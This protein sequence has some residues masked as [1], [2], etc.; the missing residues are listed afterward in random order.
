VK[1]SFSAICE[2]RRSRLSLQTSPFLIV[3]LAA[4]FGVSAPASD[5]S[6]IVAIAPPALAFARY[7]AALN[8]P[9]PFTESGPVRVD[10]DASLPGLGKQA[11]MSAIRDT[12]ASERGQYQI[13]QLEGDPTAKREVIARYLS[14]Q[15]Q[16]ERL[17]LSSTL[18]TPVNYKFRYTGSTQ[19]LGT[20]L[21]VFQITPRKKRIGLIQG[22]IWIDPITGIAVHEAGHFVKRPSVFL[23]RI[24][25]TRDTILC[26]GLPYIRVTH[27][28][29]QTR[30]HALRAELTITERRLRA[31]DQP[32]AS[33][34]GSERG[35]P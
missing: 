5:S 2:L 29:I 27:T 28:A 10:I 18:I 9:S 17:P 7:I 19:A 4:M 15:R 22:Q 6:E 13:L 24:D 8:Q 32:V 26:D 34:F 25:I 3:M 33:Q 11:S 35:R 23:S 12:A 1:F 30:L 21:Y 31:P 20:H 14:A 16:A